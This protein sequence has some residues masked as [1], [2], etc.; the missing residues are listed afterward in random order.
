MAKEAMNIRNIK[1]FDL[2]NIGIEAITEKS[3]T[4]FA[5]NNHSLHKPVL[6]KSHLIAKTCQYYN[7]EVHQAALALPN[8]LK[9]IIHNK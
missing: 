1:A 3:T 6:E 5:F 7:A 9:A 8:F 4:S 2:K